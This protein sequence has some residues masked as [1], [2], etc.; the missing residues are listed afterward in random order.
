[1]WNATSVSISFSRRTDLV[2]HFNHE[3]SWEAVF[4]FL[5]DECAECCRSVKSCGS[6]S[7]SPTG[8]DAVQSQSA[9]KTS[10]CGYFRILPTRWRS[11]LDV[12]AGK[13]L[14]TAIPAGS[15]VVRRRS[16][17]YAAKLRSHAGARAKR[18]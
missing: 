17:G 7:Q 14:G 8:T 16:A 13:G 2:I 5:P 4:I 15:Q 3:R 6:T 9:D 12:R 18:P 1:M 11:S 10:P